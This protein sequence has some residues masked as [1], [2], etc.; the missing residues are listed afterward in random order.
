[1]Q[2]ISDASA[3]TGGSLLSYGTLYSTKAKPT[4]KFN[5]NSGIYNQSDNV[6][7]IFTNNTD[8]LTIDANQVLSGNA[9]G[10]TNLNYIK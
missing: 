6:V 2:F 1:M 7:K 3:Q 9:T 8:V 4:I 5:S 10:L